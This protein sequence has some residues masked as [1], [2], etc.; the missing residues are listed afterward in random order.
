M[1]TTA[2]VVVVAPSVCA[3][4]HTRFRCQLSDGEAIQVESIV[5]A[6]VLL[7]PLCHAS[8]C[9]LF[10]RNVKGSQV[11]RSRGKYHG[12]EVNVPLNAGW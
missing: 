3:S 2:T 12:L 1:I 9:D 4:S 7:R 5:S 10:L 8:E 6:F 11:E